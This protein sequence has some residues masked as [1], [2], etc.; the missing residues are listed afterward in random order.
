MSQETNMQALQKLLTALNNENTSVD[1]NVSHQNLNLAKRILSS[2]IGEIPSRSTSNPGPARRSSSSLVKKI[3]RSYRKRA[4]AAVAASTD[5]STNAILNVDIDADV[6]N[7]MQQVRS[8]HNDLQNNYLDN[9]IVSDVLLLFSRL[10][11]TGSNSTT[12][13]ASASRTRARAEF[14]TAS[15]VS[16]DPV[17]VSFPNE[18]SE[19][20]HGA[21]LGEPTSSQPF[22]ATDKHMKLA[23]RNEEL[24]L[25]RE[26]I[27]SLQYINGELI[28]FYQEK[29][30]TDWGNET[31]VYNPNAEA[32][33]S[34]SQAANLKAAEMMKTYNG[35]RIRP[36]LLPFELDAETRMQHKSSRLLSSGARD[37]LRVCGEAGWL[38]SRIQNYISVV[39][40]Q[41]HKATNASG[42]VVPRA[43]AS[44][45][46]QEINSYHTF[47]NMLEQQLP[48]PGQGMQCQLTLRTLMKMLRGPI[49][50]LRTLA[51]IVD[52]IQVDLNGGQ[53]LADL[54]LH[55]MHG[56]TRHRD[57]STRILYAASL[58]WYDL[59]Y[60]W[61]LGGMLTAAQQGEF[62]IVE[63]VFVSDANLWHG[64]YLLKEDQI[65]HV[66]GI[67]SR[68]G[69]IS[70]QLAK[71]VLI[72]GKGLN[73]IRKCLHDSEWELD[74]RDILPRKVLDSMQVDTDADDNNKS[75]QLKEKLGFRFDAS[76]DLSFDMCGR[77]GEIMVQTS[78]EKTVAS[79]ASQVHKHIL[80]SLFEQ[81]HLIEHLRG[82][83][84]ILFLGQGDFI[85]ALMDSLH[86]EFES[87]ESIN[88][89]YMISLM[90]IVHD[91]LRSTNAKFL[92][93]YVTDRV[94][95]RLISAD[96]SRNKFW[97]GD[98]KDL[99]REGWDIFTLDYVVDTPL[100]A[101]VHPDAMEKYYL[102][103]DMLFRL[104][105]LEWMIN[106][107]WRHST[108]LNHSLQLI[109]SKFGN[110]ELGPSS[111]V[112]D[113]SRMKRLLRKFSMTRQCMLHFLTNLQ[114]YLMFEVLESGWKELAN[115]LKGAK[116]LDEVITSHDEYLDDILA[117]SLVGEASSSDDKGASNELPIQLRS[118]LSAAFRFCAVHDKIFSEGVE[119]IQKATE[120]RRGAQKR[121][122]EGDWGFEEFDAD[123][124]GLNFKNLANEKVLS[125]VESIAEEFDISLRNLLSMLN[126]R[127]NGNSVRD[128]DVSSPIARPAQTVESDRADASKNDSLRFLTF[129]LDFSAYYGL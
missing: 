13:N 95:V 99:E 102:M 14:A 25:L 75:S 79:A 106:N 104:K 35:I 3:E 76:N 32:E 50:H 107:T 42:G 83:K 7:T 81:H 121:S 24:N 8:L 109:I 56:D 84:D 90:N 80:S 114:S 68:G 53:L 6:E 77:G 62:F 66:P 126:A 116:T 72:V 125:E 41:T 57:I 59:L 97:I 118:V 120:K 122:A 115:N 86:T 124:E 82:L 30:K 48:H 78:L 85:C 127:I 33:T 87:R 128:V 1:S 20:H 4:A 55:T 91:C 117:K 23:L 119:T 9:E 71:E 98:N 65:P 73:F 45:L 69:L 113:L 112:N 38:Y 74:L 44:A 34:P 103:F 49:G 26:C 22:H 93:K 101:V 89:I 94:Q 27:H 47:L 61:T 108:T 46:T 10:V 19:E 16:H 29:D 12:T 36:G 67:G 17:G 31:H 15:N 110:V 54:Y 92:P 51:L 18:G 129:R 70:E 60:D 52:G 39:Q 88:E 96:A 105:K 111:A 58:P 43:L 11:G 123:V 64:R 100:T 40:T 63:D 2:S 37:A 21:Q 5:T 28:A